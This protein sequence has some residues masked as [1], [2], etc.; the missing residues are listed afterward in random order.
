L[1]LDLTTLQSA[2]QTLKE[3]I[4]LYDQQ[5]HNVPLKDALR[6]SVIQRFEYTYELSWKLIQRWIELNVNP[7]S[8]E[9]WS[10]KDLYRIAAQKFLIKDPNIW[11]QYHQA[12]NVAAHTYNQTNAQIAFEAARKCVEDIEYL[13]AQLSKHND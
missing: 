1:V 3:A 7:E 2:L 4:V 8:A 13:L 5:E 10:R 9:A 12:R 11:F 6:D